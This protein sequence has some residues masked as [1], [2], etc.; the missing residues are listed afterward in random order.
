MEL[1]K[2]NI[3]PIEFKCKVKNRDL[4]YTK[5]NKSEIEKYINKKLTNGKTTIHIPNEW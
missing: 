5:L 3:I 2:L 1:N 4:F